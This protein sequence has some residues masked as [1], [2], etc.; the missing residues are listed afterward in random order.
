VREYPF[1][2][3]DVGATGPGDKLSCPIAHQGPIL[4]LNGCVG[5][6]TKAGPTNSSVGLRGGVRSTFS[7]EQ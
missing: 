3:D 6:E 4:L 7:Q 2:D 5:R 1:V